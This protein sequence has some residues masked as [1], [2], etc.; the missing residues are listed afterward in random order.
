MAAAAAVTLVEKKLTMRNLLVI[1]APVRLRQAGPGYNWS[2]S[3]LG[4]C[5][6]NERLFLKQ[7]Q[8]KEHMD[9]TKWDGILMMARHPARCILLCFMCW[10]HMPPRLWIVFSSTQISQEVALKG[11]GVSRNNTD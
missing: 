2:A 4:E 5:Q 7:E 1:L 10:I 3:L 9:R 8:T 11:K 6:A